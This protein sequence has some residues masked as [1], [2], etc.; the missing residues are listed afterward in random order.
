M[1]A[2]RGTLERKTNRVRR[3]QEG[4]NREQDGPDLERRGPLVFEDVE[5]DPTELVN[6]GVV[7]LCQEADFRGRHRVLFRQEQLEFKVAACV[8]VS[9]QSVESQ[10]FNRRVSSLEKCPKRKKWATS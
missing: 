8:C 6:V 3:R 1:F 9:E 5:A 10:S 4:L 7:D 2:R